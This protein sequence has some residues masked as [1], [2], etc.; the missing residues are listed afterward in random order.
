MPLRHLI[1]RLDSNQG[2]EKMGNLEEKMRLSMCLLHPVRFELS[3]A[4]L[5]N[6]P[7]SSSPLLL[8]SR[9]PEVIWPSKFTVLPLCCYSAPLI[10]LCTCMCVNNATSDV[11]ASDAAMR[12]H[13][14]L[15]FVPK[16]IGPL[17]IQIF[18]SS[19]LFHMN[20]N[21]WRFACYFARFSIL[22]AMVLV[23]PSLGFMCKKSILT[24]SQNI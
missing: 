22:Y 16:K 19:Y 20:S 17:F 24:I 8:F 12:H 3:R 14:A 2:R 15:W 10:H 1:Q 5:L 23:F 6:G 4:L 21:F 18:K 7:P 11:A 13:F 9:G